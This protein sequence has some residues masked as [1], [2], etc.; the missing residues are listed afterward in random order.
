[1]NQFLN[2]DI[3]YQNLSENVKLGPRKKKFM[4]ELPCRR[5]KERCQG[6]LSCPAHGAPRC[7]LK[8]AQGSFWPEDF[9]LALKLQSADLVE[10][11]YIPSTE[12]GTIFKK[13]FKK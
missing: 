13:Q 5:T 12:N 3:L 7:L 10:A 9:C 11:I 8:A 4:N 6:R 1:M 2:L